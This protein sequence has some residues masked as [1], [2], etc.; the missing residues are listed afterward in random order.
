MTLE[1]GS[2]RGFEHYRTVML[3]SMT[4]GGREV[5]CAISSSAMDDL[6][7]GIRAKPNPREESNSCGCAIESNNKRRRN[8]KPGSS[9]VFPP[10]ILNEHT[11]GKW[12]RRFPNDR[13]DGLLDE[14]RP[15]GP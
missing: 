2:N 4:D 1:R 7:R 14:A 3:F 6:D 10:G 12:R 9:K 15:G 13:C 11:V 8:S 5:S